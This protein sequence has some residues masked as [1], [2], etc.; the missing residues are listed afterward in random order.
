MV[1]VEKRDAATLLPLI[2][3]HIRPGTAIISD[4]WKA[5]GK[6]D[7]LPELYNHYMVNHSD[8]DHPFVDQDTGAHTN[9]IESTWQKFKSRHKR[10]HGT[11]RSLLNT[12]VEQFL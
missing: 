1:S 8:P 6:I 4:C 10:E 2:Q 11:A 12:Y 7:E 3:R 5:Y 9:T